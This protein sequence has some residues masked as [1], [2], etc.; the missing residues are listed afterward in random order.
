[1]QN[2]T[3][4]QGNS[5]ISVE[6]HPEYPHPV[7]IKKSSKRH[8]SRRSLRSLEKE[9]EMTR[10][11]N[12]VE[13]VRRALGQQSVEN[14]PALILE[15]IDGETLR[16]YIER[17]TLRLR[18]KL[19]IAVDLTRILGEIHQQYVMHLDLN[20]KNILIANKHQVIQ[21]IDL[22]Y[23]SRIDR[24]GHQKVRSDQLLGT[25]NP[26]RVDRENR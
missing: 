20:S 18:A 1:M 5:V 3:I 7:V 6:A 11:L 19:E 15:Y 14:Q 17:K 24:R 22:G 21:L 13:G 9:Y 4:Y 10:S 8:P 2:N 26:C 25:R 16:D 12:A 23:A